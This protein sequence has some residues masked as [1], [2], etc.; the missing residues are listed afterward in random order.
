ML[1]V[2]HDFGEHDTGS[3]LQQRV[4]YDSMEQHTAKPYCML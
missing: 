2:R 4:R 1:A 3:A